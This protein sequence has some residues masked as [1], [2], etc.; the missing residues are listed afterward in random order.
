M[1]ASFGESMVK[2]VNIHY[3]RADREVCRWTIYGNPFTHLRYGSGV[4]VKDRDTAVDKF[5]ELWYSEGMKSAREAA[6]RNILDNTTIGCV[7]A[8]KRC[9]ADIIAG[10]LNWKRGYNGTIE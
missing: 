5:A 2:V 3:E 10:Y 4:H 7:C 1:D 9:H 8:P 6:L